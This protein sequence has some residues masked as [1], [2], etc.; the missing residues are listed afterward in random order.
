MINSKGDAFTFSGRILMF[1]VSSIFP[2]C[3]FDKSWSNFFK[4]L[5]QNPRQINEPCLYLFVYNCMLKLHRELWFCVNIG[6]KIND[7]LLFF[8]RCSLSHSSGLRHTHLTTH[9][10]DLVL[11]VYRLFH[12]DFS[13]I[14]WTNFRH[15]RFWD[16]YSSNT[17]EY[18]N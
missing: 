14:I 12:E 7:I 10:L 17:A 18:F 11:H 9:T 6:G 8:S 2:S 4:K 13:P 16:N 1:I 3:H 15:Y 5:N